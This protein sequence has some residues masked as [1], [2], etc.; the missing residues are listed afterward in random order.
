MVAM[1]TADDVM[2]ALKVVN[3][4]E[5]GIN[6][7]DLGLVYAVEVSDS[8]ASIVFTLTSMGCP[9]GAQI[10]SEIRDAAT[11]VEGISSVTSEMTMQPAWGPDKMSEFAR[12]ALG[13]F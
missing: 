7:V 4:P 10:E 2:E 12:S 5:I 13:F 6:I 8:H 11:S 1:P 3:D 9:A